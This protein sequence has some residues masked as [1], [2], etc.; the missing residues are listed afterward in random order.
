MMFLRGGTAGCRIPATCKL[1]PELLENAVLCSEAI[2]LVTE[3]AALGAKV[4]IRG[5]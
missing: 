2:D 3:F 4:E 5:R 1:S